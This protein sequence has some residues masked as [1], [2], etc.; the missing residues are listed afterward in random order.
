MSRLASLSASKTGIP[1]IR[2]ILQTTDLPLPIP[3]VTPTFIGMYL[4]IKL[5]LPTNKK[6]D[7]LRLHLY[8][9]AIIGLL[10]NDDWQVPHTI[11]HP[12]I[13]IDHGFKSTTGYFSEIPQRYHNR[14]AHFAGE[15]FYRAKL[16]AIFHLQGY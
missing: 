5:L 15:Q 14:K 1:K 10:C 2:N 13:H 4:P 11:L 3:P 8:Q 16:L 9:L 12:I 6:I 7:V